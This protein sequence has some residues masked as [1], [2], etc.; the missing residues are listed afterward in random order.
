VS[1]LLCGLKSIRELELKEEQ[2]GFKRHQWKVKNI[3]ID[4]TNYQEVRGNDCGRGND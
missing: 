3:K 4:E 1:T 2:M